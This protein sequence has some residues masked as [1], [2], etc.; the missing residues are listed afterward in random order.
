MV[1][2]WQEQRKQLH[3]VSVVAKRGIVVVAVDQRSLVGARHARHQASAG[4]PLVLRPE[5]FLSRPGA[6][7]G[8]ERCRVSPHLA[9]PWPRLVR[10]QAA[11]VSSWGE[12]PWTDGLQR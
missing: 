5:G 8:F 6:S 1:W 3:V 10:K 7:Q 9:I 2:H 11:R 12:P 4:G